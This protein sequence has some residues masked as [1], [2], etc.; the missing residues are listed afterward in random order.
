MLQEEL[1][2]SVP[3]PE[4]T[5]FCNFFVAPAL[6]TSCGLT[7]SRRATKLPQNLLENLPSVTGYQREVEGQKCKYNSS[8][9]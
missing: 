5:F 7:T 2:C 8:Y 3:S 9:R 1:P 6:N 4:R